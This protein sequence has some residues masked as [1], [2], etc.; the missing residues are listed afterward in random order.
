MTADVRKLEEDPTAIEMEMMRA[1][2]V[3]KAHQKRSSHRR[4]GAHSGNSRE[5]K[6][7]FSGRILDDGGERNMIVKKRS[8][9]HLGEQKERDQVEGDTH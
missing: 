8:D 6:P 5:A 9:R 7:I 3:R 1:H 4:S 2:V